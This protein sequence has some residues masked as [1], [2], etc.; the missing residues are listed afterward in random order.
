MQDKTRRIDRSVLSCHFNNMWLNYVSLRGIILYRFKLSGNWIFQKYNKV[1][2]RVAYSTT[3]YGR[4]KVYKKQLI[5][6]IAL[7]ALQWN[8]NQS[9]LDPQFWKTNR[10]PFF[11]T[12][13]IY[14]PCFFYIEYNAKY[15]VYWKFLDI[16][17]GKLFTAPL[18]GVHVYR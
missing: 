1:R 10:P 14:W 11:A 3:I 9:E 15:F 8:I 12:F 17:A 6:P 13:T 7:A 5:M 4:G 16:G 2:Y 18:T